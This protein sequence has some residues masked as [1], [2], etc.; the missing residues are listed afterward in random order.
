VIP[1]W[2]APAGKLPRSRYSWGGFTIASDLDLPRL[3][4]TQA[5]AD[6]WF[7]WRTG[8]APPA[9]RPIRRDELRTRG[10]GLLRVALLPEGIVRYQMEKVG[11]FVV[12]TEGRA[13]DFFP[14]PAADP[15][16]VE[17]LLVNAVLPIYAGLRSEVCLHASAVA[18]DG[19]TTVFA[20]PSGSGKSTKALEAIGRGG[21]L[22]GDDAAVIRRRGD[23]WLVYPGARTIRLEEPSPQGR[24]WRSGPKHEWFVAS[25][26]DP[27]ALTEVVVLD[28]DGEAAEAAFGGSGLL[29]A[30][31]SL[32]Q[33]WVWGDVRARRALADQTAA[34]CY[35][36]MSARTRSFWAPSTPPVRSQTLPSGSSVGASYGSGHA[37]STELSSRVSLTRPASSTRRN[38]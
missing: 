21:V 37:S 22:L 18:R 4:R 11:L 30:L 34:L 6:T 13:I 26:R 28:R 31:L 32:Q 27:V 38:V 7:R 25:A 29:R 9:G 12:R 19:E 23:A 35:S 10:G 14:S 33:G 17:H 1:T 16:R 2:T 24:S 20:G 3:W 15:M 36:V 8:A 5:D